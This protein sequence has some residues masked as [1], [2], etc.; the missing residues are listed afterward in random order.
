GGEQ[1]QLLLGA[2]RGQRGVTD[3]VLEVEAGIVDP[4]RAPGLE[5]RRGQLLAVARHQMQTAAYVIKELVEVGRWALEDQH[6]ADMHVRGVALLVKERCVDRSQAVQVV[7]SHRRNL[8]AERCRERASSLPH[9][10]PPP[11]SE[12]M[13]ARAVRDGDGL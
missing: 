5:W 10:P 7:L 12:P 11:A 8:R 13:P 3:V 9:G 1:K 2:G 6:P 4:Q